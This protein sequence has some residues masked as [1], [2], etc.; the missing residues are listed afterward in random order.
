MRKI[1]TL[2]LVV[3]VAAF[4]VTCATN[5]NA[6]PAVSVEIPELFSPDPDVA[7]DK[8]SIN[9]AVNHP[10]PIKDWTIEIQP[11][12]RGSGQR[13]NVERQ[14]EEGQTGG[15]RGGPR[16]FFEQS[17]KGKPP[18][19]WQW[20]GRGTSG[21]MVQSAMDYRFTLTVNDNFGNVTVFNDGVIS[22]DVLVRR[23][24]DVLRIIVPSIVFQGN[25][26]NFSQVFGDEIT[27][28]IVRA[29]TRIVALIARALNRFD[30]YRI[31]VEG[32]TN[33]GSP[34]GSAARTAEDARNQ[35]ISESRANAI[36]NHLVTNHNIARTR[37]TARGM[38][39]T[40]TI[41]EDYDNDDENWKNRRV[42]FILER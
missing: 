13:E 17:G 20:N 22:T 24:G 8:M 30:D 32:H 33:P 7:D 26:S 37:L 2:I 18:A 4:A 14:R 34:L 31:T 3:F 9:I 15:R 28:E 25:S 11:L 38:S 39:G 12:R 19:V 6:G 21:E 5:P 23:E 16:S 42:E 29:N 1:I 36:I 27:E 41:T 40:R 35:A 10:V